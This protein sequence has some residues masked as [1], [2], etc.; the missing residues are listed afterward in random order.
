MHSNQFQYEENQL[1]SWDSKYFV[2]Q[3]NNK[4]LESYEC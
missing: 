1:N 4:S 2:A 3:D